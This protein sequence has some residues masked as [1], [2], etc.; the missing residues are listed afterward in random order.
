MS[1]E[2]SSFVSISKI[3]SLYQY[4][5][6]WDFG[7]T[8]WNAW[9]CQKVKFKNVSNVSIHTTQ[10]LLSCSSSNKVVKAS[11]NMVC[12]WGYHSWLFKRGSP[13]RKQCLSEDQEECAL[14]PSNR[15]KKKWKKYHHHNENNLWRTQIMIVVN[16][17]AKKTFHNGTEINRLFLLHIIY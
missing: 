17:W 16:N 1:N 7:R 9:I 11:F 13:N 8:P 15:Q 6:F 4:F 2:N 5:H 12:L 14:N 3:T 10:Y